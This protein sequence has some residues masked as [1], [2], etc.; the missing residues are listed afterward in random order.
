MVH[1]FVV[2]FKTLQ[3]YI[4][5]VYYTLG[6]FVWTGWQNTTYVHVAAWMSTCSCVYKAL[7]VL[8]NFLGI[9]AI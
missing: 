9:A 1:S 6:E 2:F 7:H 8:F 3:P 5:I 4:C